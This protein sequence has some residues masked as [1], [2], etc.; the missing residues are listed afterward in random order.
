MC[1]SPTLALTPQ[2]QALAQ[3]LTLALAQILTLA[4]A[5]TLA[6]QLRGNSPQAMAR[7]KQAIWGALE[8]GYTE[9]LERGWALLQAHWTHPDFLEGPRAF[10]EGREPDWNPDPDAQIAED[11]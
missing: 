2:A 10:A 4:L 7:S 5:Q 6:E 11:S 1:I 9:A 3:I 8:H